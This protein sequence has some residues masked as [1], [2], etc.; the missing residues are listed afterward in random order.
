MQ[1][2]LSTLCQLDNIT[3]PDVDDTQEALVLL[4]ELLLVKYLHSEDTVF[5][6]PATTK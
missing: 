1:R 3:N 6:R 5:A 2:T 4:F